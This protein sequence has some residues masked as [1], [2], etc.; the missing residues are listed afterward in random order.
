MESRNWSALE[1]QEHFLAGDISA[2]EIVE[3]F[4]DEIKNKD[5]EINAFITLTEEEARKKAKEIDEKKE[6]GQKLGKLAG[7]VIS[8]KD[9]IAQK[10]VR[11]TCASKMLSDYISPYDARIVEILKEEDAILVGKVNLDEFAMGFDTKTSY[12]GVTRNPIDTSRVSG[13]SSGG[14]SAAVA[15]NFSSLSVGTDTGGSVRQPASFCGVVG[16]KPSFGS[17]SRFGV[18]SMAN[19]FDQPGVLG[20]NVK[21]VSFLLEI[22]AGPDERDAT[23]LGNPSLNSQ[24]I[25]NAKN[26]NELKIA[27]PTLF[28]TFDVES[29][30]KESFESIIYNLKEKGAVV[31]FVDIPSL[32][33]V[34]EVYHILVNG[35]ITPN[36]SRFDGIRYGFRADEYENIDELYIR[37]R[38]QGFG[39]EVKRRIM[40]G[41]HILSMD[42]SKEY[43]GK[44]LELRSKMIQEFEEVYKE[45]DMI[46]TPT[47]PTTAFKVDEQLSP[48][49]LFMGD[50]FTVPVNLVGTCAISLP[51]PSQGLPV[52]LQLIGKKFEDN[53]IIK[54]AMEI[55]GGFIN[56]L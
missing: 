19:T 34:I 5:K 49:Q 26:L 16:M 53:Q 45:Y 27:I 29:E 44:A 13:G 47:A 48:K 55:E 39:N 8:V 56:E 46:M 23:C 22:L 51:I 3:N 14:S 12:F 10:D 32:E 38:S 43:Y 21:D 11:M 4:L 28:K 41:T 30:V 18:A 17:I 52:G 31:K 24:R 1:Y 25:E 9:N 50:M 40:M 35:E 20:K 36:M 2:E 15:G 42:N 6:K 7:I 33:A 54:T 37:T